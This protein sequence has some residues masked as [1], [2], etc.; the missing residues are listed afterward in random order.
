MLARKTEKKQGG[1]EVKTSGIICRMAEWQL[2]N[3]RF[4]ARTFELGSKA[5]DSCVVCNRNC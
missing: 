1:G 4:S 2:T 3:G 5:N